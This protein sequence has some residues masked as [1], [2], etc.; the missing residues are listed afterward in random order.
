MIN[1]YP[2]VVSIY[3]LPFD[4]QLRHEANVSIFHQGTFFSYEEAKLVEDKEYASSLFPDK[5]FFAGLF[6]LS[7]KPED[8]DIWIFPSPS[9][10]FNFKSLYL[11]LNYYKAFSSEI[12]SYE[13]FLNW[14]KKHIIFVDHHDMHSGLGNLLIEDDHFIAITQDGGGDFGDP[15]DFVLHQYKGLKHRRIYKTKNYY[16]APNF[17]AGIAEI[18]SFRE[19]GK[20]SGLSAYGK[21]NEEILSI[22]KKQISKNKDF[23]T[24]SKNRKKRSVPKI[25]SLKLDSFDKDKILNP[26][27]GHLV[28]RDKLKGFLPQDIACTAE[29]FINETYIEYLNIIL[30]EKLFSE[31]GTSISDSGLPIFFSGGFFNNV[32][33]NR[34][35]INKFGKTN[36]CFFG[37]APGD[38]GLSLGSIGHYFHSKNKSPVKNIKINSALLGPSFSSYSVKKLLD[39]SHLKYECYENFNEVSAKTAKLISD[40][41]IIGFFQGRAE[42]GPRS[43]GSR[44]I[45]AD[46][47]KNSSKSRLNQ[48]AKKR[49]WF[50]PFAPAILESYILEYV[51]EED[52]ANYFMQVAALMK[53][54]ACK[55][56]PAAVHCDGT[57]R[58]QK[59]NRE[60]SPKFYKLIKEFFSITK[61]PCLLNT[62][63]NRHGISTVGTPRQAI[64]HLLFSN[65]DYL[66]INNFIVSRDANLIDPYRFNLNGVVS[67]L[68]QI[69]NLNPLQ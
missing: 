44:S 36:R 53:V 11:L 4:I 40:G 41:S 69:K 22:L 31:I 1:N 7:L 9:P 60:S 49:D 47:R 24:Y 15:Y 63:F 35:I 54:K 51:A 12:N 19:N 58:V 8:I 20:V 37:M 42:Y 28:L 30:K 68:D 64:E 3:P 50:M 38:C 45:L 65:I 62:S 16:N 10:E 6:E 43:L 57:S 48:L 67:E 29:Y 52:Y 26:S 39:E 17:H 56:I 14:S 32:I 25:N 27:P 5:S 55:D 2:T 61:V 34:L 21:K 46:P 13:C 59:V 18:L 66:V 33:L 23:F